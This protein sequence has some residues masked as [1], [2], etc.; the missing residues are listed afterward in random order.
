MSHVDRWPETS[1]R[2]PS[3]RTMDHATVVRPVARDRWACLMMIVRVY[4]PAMPLAS[5]P[6]CIITVRVNVCRI[7]RLR[8]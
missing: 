2:G 5:G 8:P 7:H 4:K 3:P 6:V 1:A